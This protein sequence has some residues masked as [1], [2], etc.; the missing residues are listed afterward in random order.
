MDNLLCIKLAIGI[1]LVHK[2]KYKLIKDTKKKN[3][4]IIK[5]LIIQCNNQ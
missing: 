2:S 5:I 4:L 1:S 3:M